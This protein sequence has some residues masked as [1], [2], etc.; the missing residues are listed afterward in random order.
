MNIEEIRAYCLNKPHTSEHLP[1]DDVTLVFKVGNADQNKI[2]A[3]IAIDRNDYLILKC[4]PDLAITLREHY[5]EIEG[6]Y[7]M[8]KRYWNGVSL[9]GNLTDSHIRQ[10]I[11]H[12][13]DQVVATL[14]LKV[15][16]SLIYNNTLKETSL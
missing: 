11:D 4:D 8:N 3:L 16:N 6:G 14:P 2:F 12:S 10:M 1:F 15:R 9:C 7:H 13:Y 5:S